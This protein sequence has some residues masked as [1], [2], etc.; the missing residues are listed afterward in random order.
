MLMH[1]KGILV[2]TP[3]SAMV[4]TGKQSLDFS[5]GVSA[6]DNFGIGGYDRVMGPNGQAQYWAKDLAG[7]P[8]HPHGALR[9]RLRQPRRVGPAPR[10]DERPHRPRRDARSRTPLPGLRTSRRSA[11]SS[12]PRPTRTA[13]SPSTSAPSCGR[14]SDQDHE[15]LER[16]AGMADA[17]TAV[18]Q[19]AHLGGIPVCL[20][21]IES[22]SV[23]RR[24]FPPTDGPDTYTA[25]TLFPRSSKKVAR[26]INAA[27]GN[28]PVVVL[29]N[30]SGLRRLAGV[31]A[32][33]PARVRRRD[34]PG[35]R[36]L[37]RPD[38]LHRRLPL[39]RR[40][41]RRLLQDAQPAHDGARR[42]GLLRVRPRRR[43]RG[44]RRL[45]PRRRRPHRRRPARR[46]AREPAGRRVRGRAG[47]SRD[48]ARR[49]A[50][51]RFAPRSS[52]RSPPSSTRCTAS[53]APSTVGSVDAVIDAATR[54]APRIIAARRGRPAGPDDD[55]ARVCRPPG[56]AAYRAALGERGSG[57]GCSRLPDVA[58]RWTAPSVS[59]L[60]DAQRGQA[61]EVEPHGVGRADDAQQHVAA[62]GAPADE[63]RLGAVDAQRRDGRARPAPAA[64]AHGRRDVDGEDLGERTGKDVAVPHRRVA[65]AGGAAARESPS[66][67]I[68]ASCSWAAGPE[69]LGPDAGRV[70]ARRRSRVAAASTKPVG[71]QT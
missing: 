46:R 27:S 36:Q 10:R 43:P 9:P 62:P 4:L 51:R 13:R 64:P 26:A 33:P 67:C 23:A 30:L 34:R 69:S 56:W 14:V 17:E 71:P 31:D 65:A 12:Q 6:E 61:P 49:A 45:L 37:R 55:T 25:G 41:L 29:A 19:D 24:G 11:R 18:V 15:P 42:R 68:T 16:W 54:S 59:P 7:G 48:R 21:G 2:M 20:I 5:G 38:R 1:T 63:P 53:T 35:H 70:V 22:K 32:Q 57:A 3:D 60:R 44:G 47:P 50:Q 40:R 52:V 58:V 66:L 28:R 8:R 39:P